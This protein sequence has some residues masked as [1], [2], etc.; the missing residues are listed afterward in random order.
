MSALV[1]RLLRVF[2]QCFVHVFYAANF[3]SE[4]F[5]IIQV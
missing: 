5:G 4:L 1:L 2:L 3:K